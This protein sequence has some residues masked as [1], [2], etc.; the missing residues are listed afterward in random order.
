[1]KNDKIRLQAF[2]DEIC[3]EYPNYAKVDNELSIILED[4]R[5]MLFRFDGPQLAKFEPNPK[6]KPNTSPQSWYKP[7]YIHFEAVLIDGIEVPNLKEVKTGIKGTL[8]RLVKEA[9][10]NKTK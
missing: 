5:E 7:T 4:G 10:N 3:Y 1:M 9:L 8:V 2:L 6:Y